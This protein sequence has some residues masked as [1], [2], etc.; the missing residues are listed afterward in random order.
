MENKEIANSGLAD[1]LY[2]L[3]KKKP[4]EEI[5]DAY[6]GSIGYYSKK[7]RRVML[8]HE[9]YLAEVRGLKRVLSR[10]QMIA[11]VKTIVGA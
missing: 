3:S 8:A 9:S 6:A 11:G 10:K 4:P 7:Q 2:E 1:K 5:A